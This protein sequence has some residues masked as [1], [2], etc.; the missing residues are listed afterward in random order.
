MTSRL[1]DKPVSVGV[2]GHSSSGKS[3]VVQMVCRFFPAG[4]VI[5]MTAMSQRALVY[6]TRTTATGS[7][8]STRW[9]PCARGSRT[10]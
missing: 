3:F 1:F 5:E 6:L 2:K 8:S 10:T 4:A 9:W 7:W